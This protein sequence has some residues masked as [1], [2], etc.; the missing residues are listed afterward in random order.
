MKGGIIINPF[1]VP[2]AC[3]HQANRVK[4]EFDKLNINCDIITD[5]Y[6]R[7]LLEKDKSRRRNGL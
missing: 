5:G 6:L 4:E 1:G 3:V 2:G 7:C